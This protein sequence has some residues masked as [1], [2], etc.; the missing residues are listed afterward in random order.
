MRLL[1]WNVNGIRAI[2]KKDFNSIVE[3]FNADVLGLQE[4]KAQ[5]DQVRE[6]LFGLPSLE[7]YEVFSS[8]AI[9]KG[10]F[11]D[12]HYISNHTHQSHCGNRC[13]RSRY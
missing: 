3:G 6:A 12:R 9:K 2:V 7:E 10:I 5:D 1:S 8:S 4:T 11:R 13:S